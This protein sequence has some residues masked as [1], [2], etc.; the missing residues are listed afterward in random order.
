MIWI[1]LAIILLVF[2][3]YFDAV[4]FVSAIISEWKSAS[5]HTKMERVFS[6]YRDDEIYEEVF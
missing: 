6:A 2:V 4:G 5:F 3:V 1:F